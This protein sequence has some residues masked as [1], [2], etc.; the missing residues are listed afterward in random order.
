M[1]MTSIDETLFTII[2]YFAKPVGQQVGGS[3][4]I[5]TACICKT[6]PPPKNKYI[7]GMFVQILDNNLMCMHKSFM[8]TY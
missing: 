1:M 6:T 7:Y 4:I 5:V 3:Y 2:V 8:A